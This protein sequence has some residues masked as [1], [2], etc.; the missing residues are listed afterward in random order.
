ME[1]IHVIPQSRMDRQ[2]LS[3]Y[4]KKNNYNKATVKMEVYGDKI[5][6]TIDENT[7]VWVWNLAK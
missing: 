5:E 6:F 3:E 4:L 2:Q 1:V 7:R